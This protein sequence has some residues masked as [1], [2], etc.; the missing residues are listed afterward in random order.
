[1]KFHPIPPVAATKPQV[2]LGL[3]IEIDAP[4]DA[5]AARAALGLGDE[6]F[7]VYLGRLDRGKGV[8]DLVERFGRFRARTGT[9]RLV[10]AGP[11]I[12]QPP[13]TPGVEVLGPVPAEHKYGLLAAADLLINPSPHES[14]SMVVPEAMLVGT[15]TLV[16]GWCEPMREHC[17]NSHGGLWYTGLAD[18]EVALERLL[19]DAALRDRLAQ[20]GRSY[21]ESMFSWDAVRT[22]YEGLLDRLA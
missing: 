3:P 21:V 20:S 13:D 19:T 10:L 4:C 18:F 8:H 12:E 5:V 1:M 17:E 14:F 9:G 6:P 11:V 16:N 7:A 22:R 2:V 15:P